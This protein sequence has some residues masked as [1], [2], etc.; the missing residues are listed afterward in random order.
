MRYP[1]D[2]V[3]SV[4]VRNG[5]TSGSELRAVSPPPPTILRMKRC[6][7]CGLEKP[8]HSFSMN[9]ARRDGLQSYC[10]DCSREYL[11]R[12]YKRHADRYR[13]R[14]AARNEQRRR[15][16]R[17]ILQEAKAR[18]C[19]DCGRRYPAFVMDFD[20]VDPETKR[21]TIG[22]DGWSTRTLID[23]RG[24]IA[25]CDVVCA[26]CHRLRTHTRR[27]SLGRLDSNQD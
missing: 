5:I 6:A 21:F 14:A 24:E 23:L 13:A 20:H 10:I 22:R 15:V 2:W 19:A 16:V 26:N 1:G 9:R 7:A 18:P 25:K 8:R 11:R 4:D 17:S 3:A 12:H 27:R